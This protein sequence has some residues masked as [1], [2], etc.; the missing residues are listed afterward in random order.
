VALQGQ[1][2]GDGQVVART[3]DVLGL[4]AE[5]RE[6]LGVEEVRALEV[7]FQ[8]GVLDLDAADVGRPSQNAVAE[9]SLEVGERA[10][11]YPGQ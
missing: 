7:G 10:L 5:L 6:A 8:V 2:A 9:A 1:L 4:E 11:E 3:A